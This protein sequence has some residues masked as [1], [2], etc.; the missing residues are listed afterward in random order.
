MKDYLNSNRLH[1]DTIRGKVSGVCAGI[2][3]HFSVETWIVR[4]VAIAALIF[5]PV[6]TAVAYVL[7]V[8]LLPTQ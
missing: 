6:P 1:R 4:I 7:A 8:V 5:M 2:A 3:K